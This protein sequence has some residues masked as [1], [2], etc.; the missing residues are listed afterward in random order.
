MIAKVLDLGT[1]VS[2]FEL[3]SCYYIYFQTNSLGKRMTPFYSPSNRLNSITT[4][5]LQGWL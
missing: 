4:V 5:L 1:G 3:Q 2:E